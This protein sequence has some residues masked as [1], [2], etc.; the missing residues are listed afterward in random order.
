MTRSSHGPNDA[1]KPSYVV[2]VGDIVE[3][4]GLADRSAVQ[5]DFLDAIDELNEREGTALAAPMTVS[6]G[7]QAKTILEDPPVAV[8]VMASMSESL[9]PVSVVWG[10]GRGPIATPWKKDVDGMD[11]PCFH[12]AR[13]AIEEAAKEGV[14]ARARGFSTLDDRVMSSLLR[15][16]GGIRS[17]WTDRQNEY[18]RHLR[19]R[20][21][22]E[23]AEAFDVGES[24]ISMALQRA[25][26]GDVR[27]GEEALRELLTAYR[28]GERLPSRPSTAAVRE[29]P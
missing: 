23:V 21:Q 12:R 19:G 16:I 3:S 24:A 6:S 15:L 13:I 2:V 27:E 29:R 22:R 7:D 10:L 14:W 18:V 25:R 9:H 20:T 5:Q 26:F 4:R 17:D 8:D 11:G 1:P 28:T